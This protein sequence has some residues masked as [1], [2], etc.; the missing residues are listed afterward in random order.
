[1]RFVARAPCYPTEDKDKVRQA[2]LNLFPQGEVEE[3]E[4]ELV[5]RTDSGERLRQIILDH[6]IRDTARSVLLC[7]RADGRTSFRLNKQ[8]A[9][10]GKVSFVE[11]SPA[12]GSIEVELED[13]DLDRAIDFL[14]EST[15]EV[16][17]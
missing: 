5:V 7:G 15:V 3:R 2:L 17:E 12:L 9:F 16:R 1:M 4:S 11:G 6:H 13:D 10:V 8:V 14:A